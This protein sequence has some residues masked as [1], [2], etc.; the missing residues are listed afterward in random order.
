M[1][2]SSLLGNST[3]SDRMSQIE[4][5]YQ[6]LR[7]EMIN[8]L[9]RHEFMYL[10]TSEGDYVTNRAIRIITDDL[11]IWIM[12]SINSRKFKQTMSNPSV[13]LAAGNLQIEGEAVL[14]LQVMDEQNTRFHEVYKEKYPKAYKVNSGI[15]FN[16]SDMVVLEIFP[17]RL[18]LFKTKGPLSET[19]YEILDTLKKEAYRVM[20]LD[21]NNAPIYNES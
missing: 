8:T 5:D 19:Y 6:E 13:A 16:L 3:S 15:Y 7:K 18:T 2:L 14:K 17:S 12:T 21:I 9:Q 20:A 1:I 10:A 4:L 11:K